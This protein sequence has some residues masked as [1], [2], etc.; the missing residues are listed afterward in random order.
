MISPGPREV[1]QW[2]RMFTAPK[3]DQSLVLRA[4]VRQLTTTCNSSSRVPSIHLWNPWVLTSL[5]TSTTRP[6]GRRG[7]A[8]AAEREAGE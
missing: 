5:H 1:A 7:G 2:L 8:W 4:R 6:A 3:E